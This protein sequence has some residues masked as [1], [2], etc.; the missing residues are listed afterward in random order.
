MG[1]AACSGT[2]RANATWTW[3]AA[4]LSA[5]SGMPAAAITDA[6]IEQSRKLVHVS[7]LYYHG[8]QGLLAED[9]DGPDRPGA[10]C[11]FGN[12]GAEANEGLFKLARKFGHEEGAV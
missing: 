9:A 3:A 1:R 8:P 12:S 4:S 7:N 5:R 6:L 2:S 11:F 10:K